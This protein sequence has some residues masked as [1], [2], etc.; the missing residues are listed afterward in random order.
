VFV[1][2]FATIL[3]ALYLAGRDI[4]LDVG[5][6]A[7]R[8]ALGEMNTRHV[9]LLGTSHGHALNLPEAGFDGAD[10]THGGQDLFEMAYM[11]RTVRQRAR[12]LDTVIIA[13]S[14]FSFVFDNAAYVLNGVRTRV[15]RRI[16]LYA[17]YGRLAF[18]PGDGAEYIKGLLYPVVTADHYRAG[19][20][21]LA[22][23]LMH[24]STHA[25]PQPTVPETHDPAEQPPDAAWYA[26][27]AKKRCM[28]FADYARNMSKHHPGL[29][30][31]T[32]EYTLELAR[33]LRAA[34]IRVLFFTPPYLRAY[35]A[36]FNR[37]YQ[38]Q[39]RA[40]GRRLAHV[41]GTPYLD[42]SNAAGFVDNTALFEDSDHLSEEGRVAFSRL[43]R[44]E[45]EARSR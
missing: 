42:F 21:R 22:A 40:N 30:K 11:T 15:E 18:V 34:S 38:K 13:L 26:H 43:F 29:A 5:V 32:F 24:A 8:R 6:A 31:D 9:I 3:A 25:G 36:C 41:S 4:Y 2:G 19:F 44:K 23:L 28:L 1:A 17:G 14:Y 20:Q 37:D 27:Q 45:L 12:H 39:T 33:E 35:N 16:D 10:L 7:D